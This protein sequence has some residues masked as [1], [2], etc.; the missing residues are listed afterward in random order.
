MRGGLRTRLSLSIAL[1]VLLTVA[2]VSFLANIIIGRQFERNVSE[3]EAERAALIADTIG[4][5]YSGDNAGLGEWDMEF[6][7]GVGMYALYDG[8]IVKVYDADGAAV[9]DAENHDMTLCEHIMGDIAARMGAR[10]PGI[11]GGFAARAYPLAAN[12]K[13][14]GFVEISYYGPYFLSGEDFRFLDAL[15]AALVSIGALATLAA[16]AAG[17]L[18]A[19]RVASPV[20]KAAQMARRISGGD[21][22]VRLEDGTKTREI[23]D[24]VESVNRLADALSEQERLR[25]RLTADVAHELRTPITVAA[26][27]LEAM[28]EGVWAPDA[29]ALQSVYEEI[30]RLGTLA[31]DLESLA[32]A[33]SAGFSLQ[34]TKLDMLAAAR[35]AAAGLEIEARRKNIEL[36]VGGEPSPVLADRDRIISVISNLLTNAI[37]YTPENGHISVTVRSRESVCELIVSDD[38]AGIPEKDLPL[39]FERFYRA[40]VS[41]SRATGGSGV[42]LAIVKS[43]VAAHGGEVF[44]ESELGRGSKFTVSLPAAH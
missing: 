26:S 23:R 24:L 8:Y 33:E 21:Y 42:G 5:Q 2:P 7:H 12:G 9:W 14:V 22:A 1:V 29:P 15:N 35:A 10:R 36:T 4:H 32:R 43:V 37:K 25:R 38:G 41:R 34:K 18:L 11:G 31:G 28:I 39:I 3:R 13:T 17:W 6:I 20:T 44:A 30:G 27:H 19:R 16:V 40:D